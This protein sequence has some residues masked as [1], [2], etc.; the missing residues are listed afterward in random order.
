M[1]SMAQM[2]MNNVMAAISVKYELPEG[3][4]ISNATG[5]V[6]YPANAKEDA[7]EASA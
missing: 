1:V 7:V 4:Q 6:T 5:A 2:G 3:C